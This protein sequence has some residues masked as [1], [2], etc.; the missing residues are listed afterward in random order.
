MCK[1]VCV[2]VCELCTRCSPYV[3]LCDRWWLARYFWD[4]SSPRPTEKSS[5]L[6]GS[7]VVE[8]GW[9]DF[10]S[11]AATDSWLDTSLASTAYEKNYTQV[12]HRRLRM[13]WGKVVTVPTQ[14]SPRWTHEISRRDIPAENRDRS[15]KQNVD[16]STTTTIST[17]QRKSKDLV[18]R[19]QLKR[20]RRTEPRKK[21]QRTPS[22]SRWTMT[23]R[24]RDFGNFS[25]TKWKMSRRLYQCSVTGDMRTSWALHGQWSITVSHTK[26]H[27]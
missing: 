11:Q 6:A 17:R 14:S 24:G 10:W 15:D 4:I 12:Y 26:N 22:G 1:C 3:L 19:S 21:Q 25:F 2:G 5:R 8:V 13:Y 27:V 18:N 23:R 16:K 20:T 7:K 9:R